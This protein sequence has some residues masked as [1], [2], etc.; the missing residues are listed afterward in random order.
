MATAE[1]SVNVSF[2]WSDDEEDGSENEEDYQREI[3]GTNKAAA[4]VMTNELLQ[5]TLS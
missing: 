5:S 2:S 3:L 4:S 1:T